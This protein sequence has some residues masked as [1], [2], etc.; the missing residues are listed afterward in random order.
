M[1][2]FTLGA[3]RRCRASRATNRRPKDGGRRASAPN[4]P[5]A[6]TPLCM[7]ARVQRGQQGS[8]AGGSLS[9]YEA[10]SSACDSSGAPI[11]VTQGSPPVKSD[12]N[13]MTAKEMAVTTVGSAAI[14]AAVLQ[15]VIPICLIC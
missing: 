4:L 13:A 14:A 2:F 3:P 12:T 5:E 10:P 7:I 11:Q 8:R 6:H 1:D 15:W 9:F